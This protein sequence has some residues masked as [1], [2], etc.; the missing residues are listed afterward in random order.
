MQV[1]VEKIKFLIANLFKASTEVK[2][3]SY[4]VEVPNLFER[5]RDR[6]VATLLILAEGSTAYDLVNIAYGPGIKSSSEYTVMKDVDH[7][8]TP[9][10]AQHDLYSKIIEWCNSRF[11]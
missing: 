1:K 3:T 11:K 5:L 7:I 2:Q 10:W 4:A 8:I 6:N 9:V